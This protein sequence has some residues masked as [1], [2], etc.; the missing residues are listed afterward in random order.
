M[1]SGVVE[2]FDGRKGFG[3][4]K[5]EDEK[6][7]FFSKSALTVKGRPDRA[8]KVEFK[9]DTEAEVKEG[10]KSVAVDVA[11]ADGESF[12]VIERRPRGQRAARNGNQSSNNLQEAKDKKDLERRLS[13]IE[14]KLNEICEKLDLK[15]LAKNN[16][17]GRKG[18]G[19]K[20]GK[21]GEQKIEEE[22]EEAND[23]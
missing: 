15:K 20:G 4:I 1:P 21:R 11:P 14:G 8:Q 2:F 7:Y 22:E 5:G 16:K 9:E 18:R 10:Q 13:K 19:K 17:G 23:E 3:N 6:L 12:L